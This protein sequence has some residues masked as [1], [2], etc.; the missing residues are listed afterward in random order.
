MVYTFLNDEILMPTLEVCRVL[1]RPLGILIAEPP[2]I[3]I[4]WA[5]T[6]IKAFSPPKIITVGDEVTHNFLSNNILPDISV[7]DGRV[8]RRRFNSVLTKVEKVYDVMLVVTNPPGCITKEAWKTISQAFS[9]RSR[10]LIKVIGEEDLLALVVAYHAPLGSIMAY[11]QPGDGLVL[12]PIN[13]YKKD[14]IK[15]LLLKMVRRA[16]T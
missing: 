11:G 5:K 8:R 7:I 2:E 14:K 4:N 10:V 16:V 1:R 3:A 6:I 9:L 12:V 15:N 13:Q